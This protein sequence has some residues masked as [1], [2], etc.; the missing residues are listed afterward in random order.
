MA[1]M[2][3]DLI[4]TY[5][6]ILNEE[7]KVVFDIE[8]DHIGVIQGEGN[9]WDVNLMGSDD[10]GE[11]Y[12]LLDGGAFTGNE[13]EAIEFVVSMYEQLVHNTRGGE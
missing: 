7:Q 5:A 11:G 1:R 6:A 4:A 8:D 9:Q 12:D 13:H 10:L 3:D 2:K